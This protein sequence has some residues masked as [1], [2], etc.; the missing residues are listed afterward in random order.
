MPPSKV[1][2]IDEQVWQELQKLARPLEDTPNSV[3]RR[4]FGLSEEGVGGDGWDARI[5]RLLELVQGSIGAAPQVC[6]VRKNYSFLSKANEVVAYVRPQQHKLRIGASKDTAAAAGLAGWDTERND[7]F[8]G[9]PSVR[10]YVRDGDDAGYRQ[11]A[12]LLEKL[13]LLDSQTLIPAISELS[14]PTPSG[15]EPAKKF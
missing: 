9:G 1:I 10:W 11:A 2:R 8:F 4:V 14:P 7:G 12:G 5:A 13:W 6:L 3:L 15:K